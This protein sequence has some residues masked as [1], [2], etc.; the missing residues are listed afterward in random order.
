LIDQSETSPLQFDRA[1][2][3]L[4]LF[5]RGQ[6]VA[7]PGVEQTSA[8][9]HASI[10]EVIRRLLGSDLVAQTVL[11]KTLVKACDEIALCLFLPFNG[12]RSSFL[13]RQILAKRLAAGLFDVEDLVDLASFF[14]G[15]C[16][17]PI[18]GSR[19]EAGVADAG[20]LEGLGV[21]GGTQRGNLC[22]GCILPRLQGGL[23]ILQRVLTAK[24]ALLVS[25]GIILE[26][27]AVQG[28][29]LGGADLLGLG[30]FTSRRQLAGAVS[31]VLVSG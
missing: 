21:A 5:R 19:D 30:Q 29:N 3:F 10:G 1:K 23:M 20:L 15:R 24:L 27:L 8:C 18:T 25:T 7:L 17:Q 31:L 22:D 6:F 12:G 14:T 13:G 9:F 11:A 28:S 16:L 26:L 2:K 4:L